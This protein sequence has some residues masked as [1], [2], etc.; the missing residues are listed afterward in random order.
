MSV[1]A[2]YARLVEEIAAE[3]RACGRE[4]ESVT[5]VGV[6]KRQPLDRVREAIEAGL[7]DVAENRLQEAER[8]YPQLPPVRK[9][10]IGR[11]QTNKA[12]GIAALFDL[13]QSVDRLD[14]GLALAR[15]AAVAGRALPILI[16]VNV[17]GTERYGC[18]PEEAPTLAQRLRAESSL[19]VEGV[20]AM[21]PFDADRAAVAAAFETAAK[22]LARVG[23]NTLSIGMSNDW[24]EAIR[25]GSTMVRIGTALFGE[26][27]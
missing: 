13:V 19:C 10:F 6:A 23:G 5:I 12:K 1:A 21:G 3:L 8:A 25:A 17:S 9:H 24:R 20:M 18:P 22:T 7:H 11:I 14:A 15:A 26:R 16:Q 27:I 2:R 4:E